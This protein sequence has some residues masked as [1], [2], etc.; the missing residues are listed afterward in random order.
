MEK[1]RPS[2]DLLWNFTTSSRFNWASKATSLKSKLLS[3]PEHFRYASSAPGYRQTSGNFTRGA[4]QSRPKF[5]SND[6]DITRFGPQQRD[7]FRRPKFR[8]QEV[9]I[10]QFGPQEVIDRPKRDEEI[11]CWKAHL[12][13][14]DGKLSE[15]IL[16]DV[17]LKMRHRDER[18]K[19][20]D[21]VEEL[22]AEGD[23]R[24]YPVVALTN[25]KVAKE[26]ESAKK[27][28]QKDNKFDE[29]QVEMSW[30][31]GSHDLSIRLGRMQEFLK[32][33]AKVD[34]VLGS[35][36]L[37]GWARKKPVSI[38]E[39][40]DL[41]LAVKDAASKVPGAKYLEAEGYYLKKYIMLFQGPSKKERERNN[42]SPPNEDIDT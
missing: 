21:F 34:V 10:T 25:L 33:G 30:S 9:D 40:E 24:A 13:N 14:P 22:A 7:R 41:V 38:A 42:S 26:R 31:I 20:L 2:I 28:A 19:F 37:K 4:D 6:V 39:A 32:K 18:G 1:L 17:I 12:R 23:G 35:E 5:R 15:P 29:K 36:R 16:L 3:R 27:K 8:A 11:E